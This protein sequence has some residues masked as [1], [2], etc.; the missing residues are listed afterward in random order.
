[1]TCPATRFQRSTVSLS[2][3]TSEHFMDLDALNALYIRRLRDLYSAETQLIKAL[4]K[5]QKAATNDELRQAFETHLAQSEQQVER[6]AKIFEDL[7]I[8]PKGKHCR[9]MEG[10]LAQADESIGECADAAVLDASLIASVQKA[11][12]Y[13]MDGYGVALVSSDL[14]G[15]EGHRELLQQTLREADEADRILSDIAMR[16]VNLG[17]VKD[18]G[19]AAAERGVA[20]PR[21]AKD[22]KSTNDNSPEIARMPTAKRGG[23]AQ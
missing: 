11:E 22:A 17:A 15:F 12:H 8:S 9:G 4:P 6:L 13:E 14:L 20:P 1:M 2:P 16:S 10:L 19:E 18:D 5:M 3:P 21:I 7:D 23:E